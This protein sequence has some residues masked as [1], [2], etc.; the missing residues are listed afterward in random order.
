ML[1]TQKVIIKKEYFSAKKYSEASGI[2][3]SFLQPNEPTS[4][5]KMSKS[6]YFE[7]SER[8]KKADCWFTRL[9]DWKLISTL[10]SI[11]NAMFSIK[12]MCEIYRDS[13]KRK[14]KFLGN[15]N[16]RISREF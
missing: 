5:Q 10:S 15:A 14:K 9:S 6:P 7:N 13:I 8:K 11:E 2:F 16:D 1:L 12:P 4:F 3:F